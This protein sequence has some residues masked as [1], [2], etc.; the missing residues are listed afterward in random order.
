MRATVRRRDS[1]PAAER[2]LVVVTAGY[3][4]RCSGRSLGAENP[5]AQNS[6]R[7][8]SAEDEHETDKNETDHDH[9]SERSISDLTTLSG[10][11]AYV[12]GAD[13]TAQCACKPV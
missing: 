2:R 5:I 9:K 3:G 12:E 10:E 1:T 4:V 7:W 13:E 6:R 11:R 8:S